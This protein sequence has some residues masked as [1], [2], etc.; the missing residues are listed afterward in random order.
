MRN[1]KILISG[2]GIAGPTL[3]YWLR[4]YGFEPTLVE[5]A[6]TLR[7]GGYIVDFWGLGFDVAEKMRLLPALRSEGYEINEVRIVDGRGNRV[8]G[9]SLTS[10]QPILKGRYL[11]ILRSDLAR[12]IYCTLRGATRTIFGDTVKAIE[13]DANGVNVTFEN[14]KPERF[15]LVIG[16]GGLHAPVRSLVFGP[17]HRYEH[18]L[19]YC[20]ASSSVDT[21]PH[22]DPRAYVTYAAPGRQISRYLLRGGR[23]VFFFVL[24]RNEKLTVG[25]HDIQTHKRLLH[26][27]FDGEGWECHEILRALDRCQELYFDSVSQIRMDHWSSGRVALVGDAS[28]CPSLLAGQGSSLAMA[29]AYILAGELNAAGGDYQRAFSRYE[30]LLKPLI[31]SKQHSAESFARS[32]APKTALGLFLRN[33]GTR[34]FSIPL[35]GC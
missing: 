34:L 26:D 21:Y 29:G 13:Q 10:M 4:S 19:G 7:S 15:D 12:L 11:S 14:S 22:N 6:P 30:Q 20:A 28:F 27:A 25:E 33:R 5:R 23:T 32:F 17:E 24:A 2:V 8:G 16:A 35:T 3:A 31:I 1:R 18:Y 9:F